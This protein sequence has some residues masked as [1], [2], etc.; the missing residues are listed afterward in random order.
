MN[1]DKKGFLLFAFNTAEIDYIKMAYCCAISIK[2]HLKNN[3]VTLVTD[4]SS[5]DWLKKSISYNKDIFDNIIFKSSQSKD[6]I[7][8]HYDSPWTKFKSQFQNK[9]RSSAYEF[10]PYEETI[11]LDVD[12]LIMCN[13][14]DSIWDN[15]KDFL[16]NKKATNLRNNK[17][18]PKNI[19]LSPDGIPMYWA[20][21]VY[22]KKSKISKILFDLTLFIKDNYTFYK[23][24]YKFPG[25][26]Y[27]NDYVF[28]IAVHILNG[29]IES[30]E[31]SFPIDT[32]KSMDQKDDIVEINKDDITF[33]SHDPDEPWKDIL[34]KLQNFDVHIMNKRALLR[35]SD[36]IIKNFK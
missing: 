30:D 7:R 2:T 20:T 11:L 24:L 33:L 35:H 15:K 8:T 13:Q 34:V 25:S 10:S 1:Y 22:F 5:I 6:N 31:R 21:L 14:L 27:R 3:H 4:Q 26:L 9:N 12:Y 17:F 29:F 32:I 36:T 19:R 23:H 18:H 28:S 16:I